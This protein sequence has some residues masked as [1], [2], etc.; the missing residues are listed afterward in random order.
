MRCSGLVQDWIPDSVW[1][2][3]IALSS[4]DELRDLPDAVIRNE[5]AWR[6]WYDQEALER[7]Q[8]PDYEGRLT[9]FERMCVVKVRR[10]AGGRTRLSLQATMC[11]T[12]RRVSAGIQR[13]QDADS[14]Q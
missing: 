12:H 6:A 8:M 10:Q 13:G 14:G 7:G 5:A 2:N 4:I 11:L 1:L 3:V 9:K